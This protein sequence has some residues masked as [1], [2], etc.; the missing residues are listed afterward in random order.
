LS[1]LSPNAL[2]I[3]VDAGN[4]DVV[5]GVYREEVPLKNWRVPAKLLRTRNDVWRRI[6]KELRDSRLEPDDVEGSVISSVNPD[7]TKLSS[8]A[9]RQHLRHIPLIVHAG[10]DA[11]IRI[12]YDHAQR[13]GADRIC[14]AV[15]AFH[16]LGGP[17]IAVDCGTATTFDAVTAEGEFIGGAIAPGIRI[18]ADALH[19]STAQLPKIVLKFPAGPIASDT[20][21]GMQSGVLFG[22]VDGINGMLERMR[23]TLGP[24]TKTVLTGGF[25]EL[26]QPHIRGIDA[27]SPLLVLEGA[28]RIYR[29]HHERTAAHP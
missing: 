22:A 10:V 2:V 24:A 23:A 16:L 1:E 13:L 9:L 25:A 6:A 3:A 4:T 27:M 15:A 19:S 12:R 29:H 14:N 11:G 20:I 17:V 7:M 21:P 5:F 26:L 28:L 8:S 18:A